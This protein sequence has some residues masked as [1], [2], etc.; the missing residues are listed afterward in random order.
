M[1]E[2]KQSASVD[3]PHD[4][5]FAH[6]PAEFLLES[7]KKLGPINVRYE[8][9]G[10][11][12]REKNNAILILHALSGDAHAAGY[13]TDRDKDPG[14]WDA[15]IGTGKAFDTDKYFIICSNVVGGCQGSTGPSSIN[16][17]TGKP[18]GL[19]FPVVT[20]TD[21][22]RVQEK[23]ISHLDIPCLYAVTGGSMGGMQAL[24]WSVSFPEKVK[25]T[26]VL[27][28]TAR[29]TA[30]GIAF[31]AVGRNAI[32]S[33]HRFQEGNYYEKEI[34]SLGLV[35]ARMVGHITYLSD[36]SMKIKFGRRLEV[37]EE[38]GYDF[39]DEFEVE[40]YLQHQGVKFVERF[41][42]NSY[43]YI[44]KAMDYF[45]LGAKY[46]SLKDA[47]SKTE[48][49]FLIISFSSD[50]LY[51]SYQSKEIVFALMQNKMDVSYVELNC[52]YGHDSFLLET[53]RQTQ[54]IRSFLENIDD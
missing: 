15:M 53:E 54:I 38:Y 18:Y 1:N 37:R 34:P 46:G 36:E 19:S 21:M 35:I 27:A 26:I 50:W 5:T 51:P 49:K 17:E 39:S 48:T 8:T 29:M 30:Q 40:S 14:W 7:G 4:F 22:V 16:P 3:G 42:A 44:T 41:D 9:Y 31:N 11:L 32:M 25:S 24:Q 45:D 47:F 33:D 28:S 23:L 12:N 43:L 6:P 10:E 13:Y 52:P 2:I 20:I